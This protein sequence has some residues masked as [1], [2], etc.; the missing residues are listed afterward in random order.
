MI[1][2]SGSEEGASL[3]DITFSPVALEFNSNKIYEEVYW[4]CRNNTWCDFKLGSDTQLINDMSLDFLSEDNG[5]E[6]AENFMNKNL[7]ELSQE[8]FR[9]LFVSL[10]KNI[11]FLKNEIDK[12]KPNLADSELYLEYQRKKDEAQVTYDQLRNNQGYEQ[13]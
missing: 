6:K 7:E 1:Q 11:E 12:F 13:L 3:M 9:L 4:K 5:Q 8:F 10:E 2:I